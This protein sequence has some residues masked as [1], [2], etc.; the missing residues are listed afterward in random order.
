MSHS[1]ALLWS[2]T[3]FNTIH[4]LQYHTSTTLSVSKPNQRVFLGMAVECLRSPAP[5]SGPSAACPAVKLGGDWLRHFCHRPSL[6]LPC[7]VLYP[8]GTTLAQLSVISGG[9]GGGGSLGTGGRRCSV[10]ASKGLSIRRCSNQ[11][12][13]GALPI[14]M[15]YCGSAQSESV[16]N[17]TKAKDRALNDDC[18]IPV[19]S[20]RSS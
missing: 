6:Y 10:E 20:E 5:G 11:G 13:P 19:T 17:C 3:G 18:I 4:S 8:T 2:R 14:V 7:P 15:A 9:G 1:T 12:R 16:T